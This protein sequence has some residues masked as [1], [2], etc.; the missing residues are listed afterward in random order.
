MQVSLFPPFLAPRTPAI[1]MRVTL[2]EL[3]RNSSSLAVPATP[4]VAVW[5]SASCSAAWAGVLG[6]GGGELAAGGWKQVIV[7]LSQLQR[8]LPAAGTGNEQSCWG[9]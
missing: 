8:T 9:W 3:S 6:G 1:T 5:C 2:G 4:T 7:V